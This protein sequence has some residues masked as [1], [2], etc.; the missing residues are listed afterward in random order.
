MCDEP[1]PIDYER[2]A[3]EDPVGF[4]LLMDV[5]ETQA[6]R[7]SKLLELLNKKNVKFS[8]NYGVPN[9]TTTSPEQDSLEKAELAL[10][11]HMCRKVV[12][13]FPF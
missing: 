8:F 10:T 6:A 1:E 4:R 3:K 13:A 2:L 12:E 9:A 7:N 5:W 11:E